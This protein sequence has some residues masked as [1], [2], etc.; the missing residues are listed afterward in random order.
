[1]PLRGLVKHLT[2]PAGHAGHSKAGDNV[3][4]YASK[5]DDIPLVV[6]LAGRLHMAAGIQSRYGENILAELEQGPRTITVTRNDRVTF[7]VQLSLQVCGVWGCLTSC[8]ATPH[9]C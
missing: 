5:Y 3:L 2:A 7:K 6:N 4:L 1:M 9:A 8:K